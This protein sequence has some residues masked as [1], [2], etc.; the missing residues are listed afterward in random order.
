M[1]VD[2][3][4]NLAK[5]GRH[6]ALH[7]CAVHHMALVVD[8]LDNPHMAGDGNLL[9]RRRRLHNRTEFHRLAAAGVLLV[10]LERRIELIGTRDAL[11]GEAHDE[12]TLVGALDVVDVDEMA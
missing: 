9:A 6:L 3:A 4:R 7:L 10:V 1:S 8:L 11:A 2:V 12:S 5:V